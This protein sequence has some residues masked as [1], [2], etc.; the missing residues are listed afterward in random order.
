MGYY[1]KNINKAVDET[2]KAVDETV[3]KSS[4]YSKKLV[5]VVIVLVIVGLI[6]AGY[7]L[8]LFQI[9]KKVNTI[10]QGFVK[11][12][13]NETIMRFTRDML[14]S[15]YWPQTLSFVQF[16][17]PDSQTIYLA[18]WTVNDVNFFD[19]YRKENGVEFISVSTTFSNIKIDESVSSELASKYFQGIKNKFYCTVTSCEAFWTESDGKRGV[20][21]NELIGPAQNISILRACFIPTGS[22]YYD[23][24]SCI[25]L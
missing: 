4:W 21:L 5:G 8:N 13:E 23:T 19:I 2:D 22:K 12:N 14:R 3:A 7:Y 24:N 10:L 9:K 17:M 15:E 16:K 18:N 6:S 1:I 20:A 11:E 25:G